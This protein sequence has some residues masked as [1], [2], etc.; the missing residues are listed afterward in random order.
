MPLAFGTIMGGS[1]LLIG[2]STNLA[3]SGAGQ[4]YGMEP[5]SMFELTP[6]GVIVAVL[7]IVYMLFIGRRLLPVR[8]G[9]E[10][11]TEQYSMREYTS[12]LI[13][14]PGSHLVGKTLAE[15]NIGEEMDLSV[16]GI[17]RAD[18]QIAAPRA[19]ERIVES[20][21]LIVEG[22]LANILNVKAEAGVEIKPDFKLRDR[23]LEAGEIE[24]FEVMV[25]RDSQLVGQTL[26]TLNFRQAFDLTILAVNRH[27]ETFLNKISDIKF[28]FGDVL[29]VQGN[30]RSI[31]PLV[32]ENELM[33]LEEVSSS[34]M[35]TDKRRWA[36]AAFAVFLTL[37]L[38]GTLTGYRFPLAIAV[39]IGVF[40]LLATRTVRYG[41][42]YQL[43]D[44]RLLVLIACM[45]SF[46]TAMEQ[47][48]TDKYLAS[49]IEIYFGQF[50]P[51]A[52]L[53]GFFLLTVALTQ[54]MSNQAAALVVLPVAIQTALLFG[55][56][57][58]TFAVIVTY[59]ASFSFMTPL[60]P[61]CVLV[62]TPGRYSFMDFVKVGTFLTL[63][64]FI[65]SIILVPVFW[66][67]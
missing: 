34:S 35:R 55:L 18:E 10:S 43:I 40:I 57:P 39:L 12:E 61:A 53:A 1:C 2:T 46:G 44:F 21:L 36:I 27:G 58:R 29:L 9:E 67:L 24:L 56:N 20:D 19:G 33:L 7:G 3:V 13:V 31:K 5:Y 23:D 50:G 22:T 65:V 60:E 63:I 66:G 42:L 28:R 51:T 14:L 25:L 41:K 6:V 30:Q 54:P 8:G 47:T 48:G 59:A 11:L 62:Y 16:I 52:L 15:A 38:S 17:I 37:S 49:L 26:K 64:V 4:R 32:A 45:M